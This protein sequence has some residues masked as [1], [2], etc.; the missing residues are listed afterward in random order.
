MLPPLQLLGAYRLVPH[1][2]SCQATGYPITGK[3]MPPSEGR[4]VDGTPVVSDWSIGPIC[5][6]FGMY[7]IG[8]S[9]CCAFTD[10][11]CC[12]STVTWGNAMEYAGVDAKLATVLSAAATPDLG[13]SALANVTEGGL[14]LASAYKGTEARR[15]LATA[16]G[17]RRGG[18]ASS[19][20]LRLCCTPFVHCQEVNEV[21]LFYRNSLGFTDV[22][23][24]PVCDLSTGQC[25]QCCYLY[26]RGRKIAFPN[27]IFPNESTF[28]AYPS[29]KGP[30]VFVNGIPTPASEAPKPPRMSRDGHY[31]RIGKY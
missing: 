8:L 30:V 10:C 5:G 1:D 19:F 22:G 26:S 13:D 7:D 27:E 2:P 18:F 11:G 31:G 3:E 15:E 29:V 20:L 24:G 14:D 25:C 16:L 17:L 6:C 28:P 21:V 12:Q 4:V 23:Y 9:C